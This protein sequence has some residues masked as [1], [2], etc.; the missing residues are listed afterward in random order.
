MSKGLPPLNDG[1]AVLHDHVPSQRK[2]RKAALFTILITLIPTVIF[3]MVW[4]DTGAA[5]VPLLLTCV[6]LVQERLTLGRHRAW[7]TNQRVILQGGED[8]PLWDVSG[9]TPK[10]AGVRLDG[11][12]VRLAY[13]GDEQAL[14]DVISAAQSKGSE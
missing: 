2:F 13:V 10:W 8:A 4:P 7:I 9:I 5:V 12:D 3:A 14:R 6:L 11:V 1:E